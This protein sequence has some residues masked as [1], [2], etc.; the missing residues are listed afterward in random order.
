MGMEIALYSFGEYSP[1]SGISQ[2]RR[3]QNLIEEI[4]LADEVGIDLFGLGEHHRDDF[5]ISAPAVVLA[6]AASVTK[7]IRLSSAVSVLS[8]VDPVRL[9]QE[10][11]TLDLLSNGRAEI[12]AGR[13]SFIESFP[14]FGY[15]LNDYEELFTEKLE[16]LLKLRQEP[17]ISWQGSGKFRAPIPGLAIHPQPK[18]KPLPVV[19]A[20][21][22]TPESADRA[23]R[24]GLP[25]A[26]AIIGGQPARFLPFVEIYRDAGKKAG[27]SPENLQVHI[28]QHG[29]L[30]DNSQEIADAV[31]PEHQK[32]FNKI[33][34]E[35]G[36]APGGREQFETGRT[37]HGHL[38]VGSPQEAIDK[39][40]FEY[41]IFKMD[42]F[43]LQFIGA[44]LG[45]DRIMK[46][47]E[48]FGTKVGPVVKKATE[49]LK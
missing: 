8:S 28:N 32:M 5:I 36:W 27:H 21:G 26:L 48:L 30:G 9:F 47:I 15:D 34:R 7:R 35:R 3:M 25:M 16:L 4:K 11:A 2:A 39:I 44:S 1:S 13:G 20:V 41:E 6:A 38:L 12:M 49:K 18:Q 46:S 22:G 17:K 33:G 19:I 29:F 40:L 24:L 14:L 23:G 10:F 43:G 42:R 31:W 45:H 37:L